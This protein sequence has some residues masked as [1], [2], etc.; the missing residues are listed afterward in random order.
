MDVLRHTQHC[1]LVVLQLRSHWCPL[2]CY[3]E[4]V[5]HYILLFLK[6]GRSLVERWNLQI[7]A[8]HVSGGW[9]CCCFAIYNVQRDWRTQSIKGGRIYDPDLVQAS[10]I[11]VQILTCPSLRSLLHL[12]EAMQT[13]NCHCVLFLCT[14]EPVRVNVTSQWHESLNP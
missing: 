5:N 4:E 2:S 12:W 6:R 8:A 3:C 10:H 7:C 11:K 14:C 13:L 1:Q 9:I